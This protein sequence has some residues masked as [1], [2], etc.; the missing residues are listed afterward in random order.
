MTVTVECPTVVSSSQGLQIRM[1]GGATLSVMTPEI[2]PDSLSVSKNLMTQANAALAP[3]QPIFKIIGAILSVKDAIDAI[4]DTLGPPPDPTALVEKIAAMAEKIAELASLIPQLSTPIMVLDIV[5]VII[6]A[7]EGI[8]GQYTAIIAQD[9]RLAAARGT[10]AQPGNEALLEVVDC[11]QAINDQLK[12]EAAA[13]LEGIGGLLVVLNLVLELIPG[14][15]PIPPLTDIGD[16]AA[17]AI[18]TLNDFV[19]LLRMV[20][21]TIPVP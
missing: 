3:L 14:V 5:D 6:T 19:G 16:D 11:A 10:A 12:V 7:L 18:L 21:D 4:P 1:P 17:A 2:N 13:S 15:D 20:R 9:V 8:V